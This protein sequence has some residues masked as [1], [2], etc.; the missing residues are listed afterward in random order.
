MRNQ[1]ILLIAS[2]LLAAGCTNRSVYDSIRHNGQLECQR[3]PPADYQNCM[4]R[5]A[6]SYESYKKSRDELL[7]ATRK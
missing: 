4:H 6:E 3:V 7:K 5:Y 2:V 1:E